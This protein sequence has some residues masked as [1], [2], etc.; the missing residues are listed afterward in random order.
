VDRRR[1]YLNP[2][3]ASMQNRWPA[4]SVGFLS[5]GE[6]DGD[7]RKGPAADKIRQGRHYC[8]LMLAST[9]AAYPILFFDG[10]GASMPA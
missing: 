8:Y 6:S 1:P 9:S 7:G 3:Q 5:E 4:E 10:S 2:R